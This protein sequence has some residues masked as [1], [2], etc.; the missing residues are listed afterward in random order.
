MGA[1]SSW[2]MLTLAHHAIVQYCAHLEGLGGWFD[3]YAV[4][5]GDIVNFH[6]A[7]AKRYHVVVTGLGISV[8]VEKSIVSENGVFEFCKKTRYP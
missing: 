7:A 3:R 8:S 4:V 1:Y 6:S 2:A 5:G